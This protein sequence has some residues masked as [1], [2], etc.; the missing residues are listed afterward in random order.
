LRGLNFITL[1]VRRMG[2]NFEDGKNTDPEE[3]IYH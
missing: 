2:S 1:N 3:E